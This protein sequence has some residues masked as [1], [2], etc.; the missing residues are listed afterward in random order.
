[1]KKRTLVALALALAATRAFAVECSIDKDR[2]FK[3]DGKRFFVIGLYEI[4]KEDAVLQAVKDAGF[5]LVFAGSETGQLDRFNALGLWGWVNTGGAID[6]RKK[7]AAA[8]QPLDKMIETYAK[9]P[10]LLLWEVPDEALWNVWYG[11]QCWRIDAEPV[12]QA[13]AIA[14]LA[15]TALADTLRADQAKVKELFRAGAW[16]EAEALADSIWT[17]LGKTQPQPGNNLS[18]A[19]Q[20]AAAMCAGMRN[21]YALLKAKDPA[22]PVWM[23]HAP[24]NSITQ[25]AAFNT[26]ADAAGCD[27][28]PV[29]QSPYQGHSDLAE[30]SMAAVG[31]YTDRMQAAAPN[32]PVLMVLQGFGWPDIQPKMSEE[33][34]KEM[35]RPT[36]D[37]TRF[38]AYDSIVHGA[39]GILYWGTAYI[40]KDSD[41][42]NGILKTA[43]E[44]ADLQPV[45][46]APDSNDPP[47]MEVAETLG[48][49]DRTVQTLTKT[50][51]GK[52][53]I[54]AANEWTAA[55]TYSAH[56]LKAAAYREWPGGN[57][58]PVE[59][60][61]IKL[62]IPSHGVQIL[63]PI[64]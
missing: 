34:R 5:N 25:L 46:S 49:V 48:S 32:K 10:A 3:A 22:H 52:D 45:L 47:R 39:R 56:G 63:E 36:L 7:D 64:K 42:W 44:L 4:P 2:M 54:I 61:S 51:D 57:E 17:R 53:W 38:M 9:H 50:V 28:Y 27:I 1:M 26:A 16:T 18:N 29:P 23:N 37:E 43:R 11:A 24:R 15:D 60:G 40:E 35:R 12:Q 33:R 55:L 58:I 59:R 31:A 20:R 14:T 21:G 8:S 13:E 41:L 62:R 19:E 6:V 30:T